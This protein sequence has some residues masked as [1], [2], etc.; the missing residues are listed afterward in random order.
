M[1]HPPQEDPPWPEVA[2]APAPVVPGVPA[3]VQST[4]PWV[5]GSLFNVIPAAHLTGID[6]IADKW[7]AITKGTYVGITKHN[8]LSSNATIGVSGSQQN[9]FTLQSEAITAFNTALDGGM[10]SPLSR[11]PSPASSL[12]SSSPSTEYFSDDGSEPR[13]PPCSPPSPPRTPSR[14]NATEQSAPPSP[15]PSRLSHSRGAHGLTQDR[16]EVALPATTAQLSSPSPRKRGAKSRAYAVFFG[17]VPGWAEADSQVS[18]ARGSLF[19][20]YPSEAAARAA[21]MHAEARSWTG[22]CSSSLPYEGISERQRPAPAALT[23]SLSPLHCG[24]WYVVYKGI[25]PG[26]YQSLYVSPL[27]LKHVNEAILQP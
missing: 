1:G 27:Q 16:P 7:Y 8:N 6:E 12:S 9:G 3:F 17:R 4:G 14:P 11:S 21:Y 22:V 19:Q 13:T 23:Q 18:G 10:D 2:A 24:T 20:S 15:S 25:Q 26:V 5:V